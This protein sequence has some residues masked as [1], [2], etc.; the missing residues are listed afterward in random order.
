MNILNQYIKL[1]EFLG[2]TLGPD[3][4]I[5]L[6]DV[7]DNENSIIA[8]ANGHI[9]GRGL[10]SPITSKSAQVIEKKEYLSMDFESNFNTVSSITNKLLRSSTLYIKDNNELIGILCINFDDSKYSDI[11]KQI[12]ELCHPHDLIGRSSFEAIDEIIPSTES[13]ISGSSIQE[14]ARATIDT[15]LQG[16]PIP[17]DRL[18]KDEKLEIV[19]A[20]DDKGLFRLKDSV[21]IVAKL[22]HSSEATIYRYLNSIKKS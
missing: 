15:I 8:I 5:A 6:H 20:L 13:D 10:G 17:P 18:T 7:R 1:V 16:S 11:S 22:L 19:K 3:Y 4:E 2:Q 12:M 21:Q 9:T 14:V